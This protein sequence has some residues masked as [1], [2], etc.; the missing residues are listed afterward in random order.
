MLGEPNSRFACTVCES[1][2]SSSSDAALSRLKHGFESRRERQWIQ[3]RSET[4]HLLSQ[5]FLKRRARTAG[6]HVERRLEA[7][8]G[9]ARI[10]DGS[11]PS[12]GSLPRLARFL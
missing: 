9:S 6:R 11:A 7:R 12:S 8:C 4:A 5:T 2:T 1:P 10:E 3:G